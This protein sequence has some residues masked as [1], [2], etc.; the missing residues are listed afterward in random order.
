LP[1]KAKVLVPFAD[2]QYR[3]ATAHRATA[4]IGPNGWLEY[5]GET[6]TPEGPELGVRNTVLVIT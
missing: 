2:H 4:L 5:H 6:D 3:E 1:G